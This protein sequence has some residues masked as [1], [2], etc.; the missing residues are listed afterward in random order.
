MYFAD[1]SE[2]FKKHE[3]SEN[4]DASEDCDMVKDDEFSIFRASPCFAAVRF[5]AAL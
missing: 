2:P 5:A 3:S 1:D 4:G